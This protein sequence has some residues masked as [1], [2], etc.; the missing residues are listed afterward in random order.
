VRINQEAAPLTEA[1]AWEKSVAALPA[2]KQVEAVVR[3]L[4]EL[5][6][7]FDGKVTPTVSDGRVTGLKFNTDAVEDISPL[8]ALKQLEALECRG[9]K[10]ERRGKLA[11][12][13]PLRG[14]SLTVLHF[15]DN[16]VSDLSPLKGMPLNKEL[17]FFRNPVE[18]LTPLRG[19]PLSSLYAGHTRVADLSPLKGMK[20]THLYCDGAPVSDLSPLQGMPLEALAV[21]KTGVSDLSPLRG[22]PLRWLRIDQ[23]CVTDLSPLRGMPLLK[24]IGCDFQPKRDAEFLRSIKTLETINSKSA[25]DFWKEV[26]GK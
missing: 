25:A 13:S 3:R 6:P 8:R 4:K 22:M 11:D 19:M 16:S 2:Q 14:L 12:L 21:P 26:D 5:N 7:G 23:T 1:E 20:L 15:D 18:D 10:G 9:S 17:G 24:E